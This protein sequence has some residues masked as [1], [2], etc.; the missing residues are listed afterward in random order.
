MS[1]RT[2][3]QGRP[4]LDLIEDAVHL[5]RTVPAGVLAVYY[6][7][8][9]P[10]VLAFLFFW[11]DMSRSA[12]A[13]E[14]LEPLAA[15]LTILFVLM[16]VSQFVFVRRMREQLTGLA[17][18][19]IAAR[20]WPG[21]I[22]ALTFWSATAFVS[23]PVSAIFVWWVYSFYHSL[24]AVAGESG[25]LDA[26]AWKKAL[27]LTWLWPG[28]NL[29]LFFLLF[30]AGFVVILNIGITLMLLPHLL[31][32][33]FGVE[34]QFTQSFWVFTNSTFQMT[35]V[36][37]AWLCLDPL[38][39]TI[40]LLRTF[41]A[42][43]LTTG[44]DIR[45]E[46]RHIR[47]NR[48]AGAVVAFLILFMSFGGFAADPVAFETTPVRT[49]KNAIATGKLMETASPEKLDHAIDEVLKRREYTWRMPREELEKSTTSDNWLKRTLRRMF[50]WIANGLKSVARGVFQILRWIIDKIFGQ[51]RAPH[52]SGK[53]WSNAVRGIFILLL[54]ALAAAIG[55][56]IYRFWL[57][58]R[59]LTT[60]VIAE[61]VAAAPDL[62]D[63]NLTAAQLPENE[64]LRLAREM[65]AKGDFR[66]AL[67]AL[68]LGGLAHLAGRGLITIARYKSNRDY[69]LELG[70]RAHALPEVM[71]AFANN[72]NV[73]DRVWYGR[74]EATREV[75]S[76][77]E[78]NLQ[79]ITAA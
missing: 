56:L 66:L 63:D 34:S 47:R 43:S 62:E 78:S 52:S 29:T 10:F 45:A 25:Q 51:D 11:S 75:V 33:L 71:N 26:A 21:L 55:Y 6:V 16:K 15:L 49:A 13:R 74:H 17:L 23:L 30:A 4:A 72:V 76:L 77:F 14:R 59:N 50:D 48:A 24:A 20:S 69:S 12:F 18:P 67:R 60:D 79:R 9:L 54:I 58:Y 70:R 41:Q 40:Y 27:R 5:L 22:S 68:Y 1:R 53:G 73:F 2:A 31:K 39:K 65:M 61:P 3:S 28:Q 19:P 64:W 44:D 38:A 7:G 36:A 32:M 35:V 42:E 37:I 46:L 8:A 57:H